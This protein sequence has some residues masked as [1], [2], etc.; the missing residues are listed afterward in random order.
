MKIVAGAAAFAGSAHAGELAVAIGNFDGVHLGHVRLLEEARTRAARR[1]GPSAVLTFAPHPARVLAPDKAPPLILSLERRLELI[2][3]AGIDVAIVEP[4]TPALAAV[5]A[6][7]FV[8]ELLIG[9]I[10]ARDV[11][12]GYDF[13]YGRGR[14]GNTQRLAELGAALG[15]GVAVIPQ[16]TVGG[17]HCSSTEIRALVRAGETLEARALLGRP[18][19][20][21]GRVV[22][23]AGRGRALGFPTANIE[24]DAELG[25]KLGIYAAH[26]EVLDGPSAGTR[27]PTALSVGRNPTFVE[28]SSGEAS[29][30]V[31]IEGYLLDFEG[32][33]Y[34]RRLRL[35]IGARLRDEQR[36]DSKEALVA[37]I[38]RDVARVAEL[39]S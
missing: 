6:D 7:A 36:F 3:A 15:V 19:E 9:A 12:V 21:Q 17:R 20:I 31:S 1:G 11:V 23:G 16:V 10:G 30:A 2:G 24:P 27:R 4:F 29:G 37:Q 25:P 38:G 33:L 5:E 14:A 26:A 22:R 13:S 18:Y 39:S 34:G 35:E 8:R 32:D 28:P